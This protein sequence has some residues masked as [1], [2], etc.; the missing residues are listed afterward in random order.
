[1]GFSILQTAYTISVFKFQITH[2]SPIRLKSQDLKCL[3]EENLVLNQVYSLS[4]KKIYIYPSKKDI[5]V[6]ILQELQSLVKMVEDKTS[7]IKELEK[8]FDCLMVLVKK[9]E[10]LVEIATKK[11]ETMASRL[12]VLAV[13]FSRSS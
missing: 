3:I 4:Q 12:T 10:K 13:T 6:Q 2:N 7:Y 8:K 9:R 5:Y 1:M 11:M